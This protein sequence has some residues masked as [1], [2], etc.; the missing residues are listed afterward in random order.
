MAA[1]ISGKGR[2]FVKDLTVGSLLGGYRGVGVS[3]TLSLTAQ[4]AGADAD[5][6][7]NII[8]S[9]TD[10]KIEL[11]STGSAPKITGLTG[12]PT[13]DGDAINVAHLRTFSS[14]EPVKYSSTAAVA[15]VY[16]NGT[17]GVGAT[18]SGLPDPLTIDTAIVV[19]NDRILLRHQGNAWENGIYIMGADGILTRTTDFDSASKVRAGTYVFVQQGAT[20]AG[21]G[22]VQTT[23]GAV[24]MGLT[25]LLFSQ[26]SYENPSIAACTDAAVTTPAT[27]DYLVYNAGTGKWVNSFLMSGK[28]KG[29]LLSYSGTGTSLEYVTST[30]SEGDVLSVKGTEASGLVFQSPLAVIGGKMAEGGGSILVKSKISGVVIGLPASTDSYAVPVATPGDATLGLSYR[31]IFGLMSR[32]SVALGCDL[33]YNTPGE[34]TPGGGGSVTHTGALGTLI[35]IANFFDDVGLQLDQ[36]NTDTQGLMAVPG[37]L[38]NAGIGFVDTVMEDGVTYYFRI[39]FSVTLFASPITVPI[40]TSL[41]LVEN[42]GT[43]SEIR[44]T[45]SQQVCTFS[46]STGALNVCA[47]PV[48]VRV[49]KTTSRVFDVC[50]QVM[51]AGSHPNMWL[52]A[53]YI[54]A[55]LCT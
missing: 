40:I 18:I 6:T 41:V 31:N 17:A 42:R 25:S 35:P 54:T 29:T 34:L 46:S 45:S 2:I 22:Y 26:F 51:D 23:A 9:S 24:T 7:V 14:K 37:G 11:V 44:Y 3:R 53:Y 32:R 38:S 19:P 30:A 55:Q 16:A 20:Q 10:A 5:M 12:V 52:A 8:S 47:P 15:G 1:D 50:L 27:G 48:H 36:F 4:T 33:S 43:A 49:S 21:K 13:D 28:G 39:S